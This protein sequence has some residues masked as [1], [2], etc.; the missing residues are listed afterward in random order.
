MPADSSLTFVGWK[1]PNGAIYQPG[2]YVLV[3]RP[4]MQFEAQW[5]TDAV[6]LT[7]HANG[8]DGNDVVET[9]AKDSVVDIWDNDMSIN[10]PHFTREG[11]K[12]IGWAYSAE[13][14]TPDFQLGVGTIKLS[15]DTHLYAGWKRQTDV[16]KRQHN[17][18]RCKKGEIIYDVHRWR[19]VDQAGI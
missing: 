8:G 2:R 1:A 5:A 6:K 12:L 15:Q 11:Y 7:Y 10:Q 13:A 18:Q 14:T 16:Y 9:W 4:W 3:T 17:I 19:L